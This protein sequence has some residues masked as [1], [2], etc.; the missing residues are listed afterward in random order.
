M[1]C[2]IEIQL[3]LLC[4]YFAVFTLKISDNAP[5]LIDL[6]D[7]IN[8]FEIMCYST[9]VT[10][11]LFTPPYLHIYVCPP[12]RI[13]D[14]K[15]IQFQKLC[16]RIVGHIRHCR[17]RNSLK[18]GNIL[19]LVLSWITNL[20]KEDF[21]FWSLT[22]NMQSSMKLLMVISAVIWSWLTLALTFF[23]AELRSFFYQK[24]F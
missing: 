23:Q 20:R 2:F 15:Y 9:Q 4:L 24:L 5:K 18:I 13:P 19:Q 6:S 10:I 7:M 17:W 21:K 1:V 8:W 3:F 16:K 14:G 22:I 11:L 12:G